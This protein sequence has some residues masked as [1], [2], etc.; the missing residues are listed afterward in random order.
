MDTAAHQQLLEDQRRFQRVEFF[1][2]PE[3]GDY[4]PVWVFKPRELANE[5]GGVVVNISEGGLQVMTGATPPLSAGQYE[6]R[7]LTGEDESEPLFKGA[8][9]QV[10]QRGLSDTAQ[11]GGFEF[12]QPN[13]LAEE[14]LLRQTT[15][16]QERQWVRC[17][18]VP[19]H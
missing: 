8:V 7:L 11:L 5:R 1:L 12:V 2:V 19:V 9:R 10:W 17:V 15:N 3:E 16:V 4:L 6:L 18:L 14:F 13:S